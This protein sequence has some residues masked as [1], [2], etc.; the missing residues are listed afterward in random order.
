MENK[1][2][3]TDT[4]IETKRAIKELSDKFLKKLSTPPK[5]T[6]IRKNE[7]AGNSKYL[8]I[9]YIESQLDRLFPGTWQIKNITYQQ[10]LNAVIVTVDLL[11]KHPI[12]GEWLTFVGIAAS[13]VQTKKGSKILDADT[14]SPQA[15]QRDIPKVKAEALKNA[16]K[17]LGN[18]FG[19]N[20]NRNWD[21]SH[22]AD[23]EDNYEIV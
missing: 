8:P 13:D 9:A 6:A 22:I 10:L 14:I 7:Y 12:S 18:A 5:P 15:L 11:V 23:K 3:T 21:F 4:A 2:A 20:L 17:S 1:L 16:C 19:R